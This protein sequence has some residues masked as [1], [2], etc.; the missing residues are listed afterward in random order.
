M[1]RVVLDMAMSLDGFVA[2]EDDADVGCIS[3]TSRGMTLA[4]GRL[5]ASRSNGQGRW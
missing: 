1:G 3:G 4:T 5:A 2:G